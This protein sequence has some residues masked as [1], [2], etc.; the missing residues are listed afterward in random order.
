MPEIEPNLTDKNRC[1]SVHWNIPTQCVLPRGHRENWHEAWHPH[2]GNRM[3]YQRSMGT[4]VTEDHHDGAWHDLQ[5]PPPDGYCHDQ[6]TGRPDVRCTERYG[7]G[8]SH[9][10][11]V[12]GCTYSWNTPVPRQLTPYQLGAD[13][14]QLRGLIVEQAAEIVELRAKLAARE[15]QLEDMDCGVV[16]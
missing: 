15:R 16:A 12:D 2:T 6:H 7:H 4:Y 3:R 5:I 14:R 11:V 13:V 8:W 1:I 10:A 9:R